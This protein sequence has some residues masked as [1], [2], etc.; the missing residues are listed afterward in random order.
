MGRGP[1]LRRGLESGA[2]SWDKARMEEL[3]QQ[4]AWRELG[5]IDGLP[6]DGTG[7]CVELEGRR[8]AVF[9]HAGG[10]H[11]LD[12]ACPHM[13]ASLGEGVLSR[14]EVTCPWHG[15]HFDLSSG[16][17]GDGLDACVAV[18][19]ARVVEGR[20]EGL[21]PSGEAQAEGDFPGQGAPGSKS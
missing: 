12:D 2:A 21:L 18:H 17:N 10:V 5:P 1:G 8:Y 15:W 3:T 6:T 7:R 16:R 11:V 14:G 13:G 19:P 4:R 9:R 20:L